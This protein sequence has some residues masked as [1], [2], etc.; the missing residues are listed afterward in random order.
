[1]RV[2]PFESG[3]AQRAAKL[4]AASHQQLNDERPGYWGRFAQEEVAEL[5]VGTMPNEGAVVAIADDE[6]VGFLAATIVYGRASD[7][8]GWLPAAALGGAREARVRLVHHAV[9][10]GNERAAYRAMYAAVA[11]GLV[12]N[13]CFSHEVVTIAR[14]PV[15]QAW[16][17]LGFGIGQVQGLRTTE[18]AGVASVTGVRQATA[19]DDADRLAELAVELFL[20]HAQSPMLSP[21]FVDRRSAAAALR[22]SVANDRSAVWIAE[23]DGEIVGFMELGPEARAEST[24]RLGIAIVT[25]GARGAGTGSAIFHAAM[26]WAREQGY[27]HCLVGWNSSNPASDAFWRALGFAPAYYELRRRLDERI[28]WA[29]SSPHRSELK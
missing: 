8:G 13:G 10:G 9:S 3:H 27:D 4:L 21:S 26:R 6:V 28:A 19:D 22:S 29:G 5:L 1:M 2:E 25:A 7:A 12:E 17:E 23:H 16:F 20:F 14:Q 24:V 15:L 11:G 18:P